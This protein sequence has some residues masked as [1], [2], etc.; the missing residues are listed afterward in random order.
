MHR[1]NLKQRRT[2][3]LRYVA[4]GVTLSLTVLTTIVLLY[5]AL[6]YRFDRSGHVTRNGLLL[7]DTKPE[8]GAVYINDQL[9]DS[10]APSRFVLTAGNYKLGL[11]QDGY[12]DWSKQVTVAASGVR[13]VDYPILVPT[14]L[15]T[16]Q[17]SEVQTP[18]LVSQSKDK[19]LE[20]SYVAGT[21]RLSLTE[22]DPKTPKQGDITLPD[23]VKRESGQL[24][25]IS[26]IEWAL[27]NK[28]VLLQQTLPSGAIYLISLD[29]TKPDEAINITT[30]Y[31]GDALQDIHYVGGDTDKI[32]GIKDGVLSQYSL[33]ENAATTILKGVRSY[34][35]YS[36]DTILFDTQASGREQVGIWKD[37]TSTVIVDSAQTDVPALLQYANYQ[38]HYYFVVADASATTIY[39]D[40]LKSPILKDQLPL[41]KLAF[42]QPKKVDFS[43]SSQF[44][45]LQSGNTLLTYDLDDLLKYSTTLPFSLAENTV[46]TWVDS[47]H[48]VAQDSSGMNY[49]LEYDGQN[50]QSLAT[51]ALGT[52]LMYSNDFKHAYQ[53]SNAEDAKSKLNA[54]S[55]VA[56]QQ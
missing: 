18:A 41:K 56:N 38:D 45:L 55:L 23:T 28:Q 10:S 12:R 30:L 46:V 6:G 49:L 54:L 34:Q 27:N 13:E 50:R 53:L 22:L 3:I 25:A 43:S 39:R 32:Y 4:Y 37:K 31:D 26:V 36:D 52:P 44:V 21:S 11:R 15:N 48:L 24:G 19:K 29:V 7:V 35:P 5:V 16:H 8:A 1:V 2:L 20:L 47:S 9:K 14:K 40:P 42:S 17:L 33:K 51:S